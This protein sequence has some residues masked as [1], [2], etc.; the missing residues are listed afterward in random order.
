MWIPKPDFRDED[1]PVMDDNGQRILIPEEEEAPKPKGC[2]TCARL[3]GKHHDD[4][5]PAKY[6]S[7]SRVW[8]CAHCIRENEL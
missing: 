5:V 7:R 6:L 8:I 3:F 1:T 4:M 2:Y